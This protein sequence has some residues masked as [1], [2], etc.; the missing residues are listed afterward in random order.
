MKTV[1]FTIV[2]SAIGCFAALMTYNR[3]YTTKTAYVEIKKVF[4]GFL[5][6]GELEAKYN[7]VQNE[8]AK[9]LDSLSFGLKVLAKHLNDEKN[10]GNTIAKEVV[11]RFEYKRENYLKLKGQYAEDN[12]ALSK[13]Y[14]EQILGQLTQLV[15]EYGK[16]KDYDI[17]LGADGNGNL[18]YSKESYNVSDEVINFINNKYKGL[19]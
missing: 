16:E 10:A 3:F 13:K 9:I 15:M 6:K 8:R 11:E 17:I 14:D 18:M 5:M 7:Q 12:A 1:I 2:F 19:E 4:N